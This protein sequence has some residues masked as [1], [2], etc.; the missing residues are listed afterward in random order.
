M[1]ITIHTK[2][3]YKVGFYS[4]HDARCVSVAARQTA[5]PGYRSSKSSK[6]IRVVEFPRLSYLT[7]IHFKFNPFSIIHLV[8][9]LAFCTMPRVKQ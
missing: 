9:N 4:T 3:R 5:F 7:P 2:N 6:V 1:R 8:F